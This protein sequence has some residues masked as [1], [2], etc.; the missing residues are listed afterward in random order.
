MKEVYEKYLFEN[1][2]KHYV[3]YYQNFV[4]VHSLFVQRISF[5][6]KIIRRVEQKHD[7]FGIRLEDLDNQALSYF[8]QNLP[9]KPYCTDDLFYGLQILPQA[10]AMLKRYIQPNPPHSTF[11]MIFDVD[12][13]G[14]AI[15]WSDRGCPPPNLSLMNLLN[16]KS[17]LIYEFETSICTAPDANIAPLRYAA[18]VEKALCAKLGGD[19]NYGGLICKNPNHADWRVTQWQLHLYTLD[20]LADYLDLS[21]DKDSKDKNVYGLGRNC[22]VFEKTRQWAYKAIRRG[23]PVFAQWFSACSERAM[24][25]NLQ[26][27]VPLS[28]A[29]VKMIAKSIAKW[30]HRRFTEKTFAEYI[31]RTH[32]TKIQAIRG[33][34]G[35]MISKGGG[36]PIFEGSIEQIKPW[37]T[38]GI[39]RRMYYYRK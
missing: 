36:R 20:W 28:E 37:E 39:S 32:T 8:N 1:S 6:E 7:R 18:A 15:D 31:T 19:V 17:H 9:R 25:Y 24:A 5:Q 12:R 35:G 34:R 14:S 26:F 38:L 33:A 10:K 22:T 30:T 21:A 11:N 13:V 3:Y 23:W 4:T 27:P 29:E 16:A 2:L